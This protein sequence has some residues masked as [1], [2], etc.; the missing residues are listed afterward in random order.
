MWLSAN[1][2]HVHSRC[3]SIHMPDDKLQFSDV[4]IERLKYLIED[5]DPL[6]VSRNLRKVFFDY[7][8]FQNGLTDAEFDDILTD[9][10]EVFNLL[11]VIADE[12]VVYRNKA[13]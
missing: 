5:S 12:E 10:E 3:H 6:R 7:L 13:T 2:E 11:D 9:I 8:R 4:L 1:I